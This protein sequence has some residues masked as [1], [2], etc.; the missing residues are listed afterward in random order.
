MTS[1]LKLKT[2]SDRLRA[3]QASQK[4]KRAAQEQRGLRVGT[5]G[6]LYDAE[7]FR[8]LPVY[9][10]PSAIAALKLDLVFWHHR[11]ERTECWLAACTAFVNAGEQSRFMLCVA[12]GAPKMRSPSDMDELETRYLGGICTRGRMPERLQFWKFIG[13]K[14]RSIVPADL[15]KIID[16]GGALTRM[17]QPVYAAEDEARRKDTE[18]FFAA[19]PIDL[20][21]RLTPPVE[22]ISMNISVTASAPA[23]PEE[24]EG[25]HMVP[26]GVIVT[27]IDKSTVRVPRTAKEKA[28]IGVVFSA[29]AG[30]A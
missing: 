29:S 13:Y 18:D 21:V 3:F 6:L 22:R 27:E 17:V 30:P 28:V 16:I 15:R 7:A 10:T 20:S 23:A 14:S 8:E 2:D 9:I 19:Q 26:A 12:D 4:S 11:H 24:D 25:A 1:R 5:E